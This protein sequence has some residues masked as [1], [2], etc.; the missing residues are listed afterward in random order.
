MMLYNLTFSP[1]GGTQRVANLLTQGLGGPFVPL[2]MMD[3]FLNLSRISFEPE[4]CCL[5]AVPSFGGRVPGP[6]VQRLQPLKG[7][8]A[9][10]VLV[11][12]YGNRAYE[13]TL[14]ELQ[15]LMTQQGFRPVAAVAAVAQ[16]SLLPQFAQGRPD[17]TDEEELRAF[18][19]TIRRR[20][21]QETQAPLVLPGNRPYRAYSGVPLKPTGRRSC[22]GCGLC[23]STCP[24]KAI[25]KENPRKTDPA[26]CVSCMA[27]AARCPMG[28][29]RVNPLL[30]FAAGQKLK[31]ACSQRKANELF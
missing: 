20:L 27:C 6:A 23:A 10:A 25:P 5:V 21:D 31:A 18:A 24:A 29:R 7:N 13:D 28:A 17:Q 16:H 15:D 11:V 19:Q 14:V 30:R 2:D 3:R 4:D 22:T 1:T 9:W 12:V 8:G 26:K